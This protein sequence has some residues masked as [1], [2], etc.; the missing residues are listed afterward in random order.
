MVT[1]I[2]LDHTRYLGETIEEIAAEKAGIIKPGSIV[3]LAQ[4]PVRAAEVLLRRVAETG[5]VVARE[6]IE[7]G[8]LNRDLACGRA[9]AHPAGPA[10]RATTRSSSRC[11]AVTRRAT[12]PCALAAV[13]AFASGAPT[14]GEPDMDAVT[15]GAGRST[16]DGPA[17]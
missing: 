13:E 5:A 10:R 3:V 9:A 7:F 15:R 12:P 14:G 2:G 8:V 16:S 1:P 17:W 6:G 4:Q 11:S